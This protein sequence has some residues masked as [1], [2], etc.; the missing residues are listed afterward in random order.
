MDFHSTE[1]V[2]RMENRTKKIYCIHRQCGCGNTHEYSCHRCSYGSAYGYL[3]QTLSYVN[4]LLRTMISGARVRTFHGTVSVISKCTL[5]F[6]SWGSSHVLE[7]INCV[8]HYN[9]LLN[10]SGVPQSGKQTDRTL[11]HYT[12]SHTKQRGD[13]W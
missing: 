9:V 2:V 1:S 11:F 12:A 10:T 7:S 6:N 4:V 5:H 3:R 13:G 8:T